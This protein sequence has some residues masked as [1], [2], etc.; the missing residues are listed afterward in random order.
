M[1][2]LVLIVVAGLASDAAQLSALGVT[3]YRQGNWNEATRAFE[4][5]LKVAGD[6]DRALI[7]SNLA[8]VDKRA[9]RVALAARRYKQVAELREQSFGVSNGEAGLAWNNAA[10]AMRGIR[11][12]GQA[13][14]WL[15]RALACDL[16]APDRA[17]VL[18]NYGSV[19]ELMGRLDEARGAFAE[20]LKLHERTGGRPE[21]RVAAM[22][23]LAGLEVRTGRLEEAGRW[24]AAALELISQR[25]LEQAREAATV[26]HNEGL[27]QYSQGHFQVA[28]QWMEK[29]LRAQQ[30]EMVEADARAVMLSN[31]ATVLKKCGDKEMARRMQAEAERAV[32]AEWRWTVSA[33]ALLEQR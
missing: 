1:S 5:A 3:H 10:D 9:G 17:I 31:Y 21:D 2:L 27:R 19:L 26:F 14:E 22:T 23:N 32:T 20:A 16:A 11:R 28:R 24:Q 33:D 8:A 30:G 25:G 18:N 4:S 6:S 15:D 13:L 12:Y 29:A 7:L